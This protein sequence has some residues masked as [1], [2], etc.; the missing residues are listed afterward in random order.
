MMFDF[1]PHLGTA[2]PVRLLAPRLGPF[3]PTLPPFRALLTR[4]LRDYAL[5]WPAQALLCK[6]AVVFSAVKPYP[7]TS[8]SIDDQSQQS[9]DYGGS[10][11]PYSK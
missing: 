8:Y 2:A 3:S 9:Y 5:S 10:G 4:I 6:E 11:G 1:S 7:E